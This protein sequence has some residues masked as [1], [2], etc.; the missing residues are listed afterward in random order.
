MVMKGQLHAPAAL[1][2][3]NSPGHLLHRSLSGPHNRS[4]HWGEQKK[5]T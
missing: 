3:G 1:S 4:G 5:A 2:P